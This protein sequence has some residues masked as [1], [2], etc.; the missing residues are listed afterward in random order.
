M[1][2]SRRADQIT[3]RTELGGLYGITLPE[4]DI[5]ELYGVIRD[6]EEITG[7]APYS[8]VKGKEPIA[9]IDEKLLE[10]Y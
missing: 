7:L 10:Y 8:R 3:E 1:L 5:E 4:R 9:L 2:L 6:K